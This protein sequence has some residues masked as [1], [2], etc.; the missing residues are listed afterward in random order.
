MYLDNAC[1]WTLRDN[2]YFTSCGEIVVDSGQG[3]EYC[4]CPYCG[5]RLSLWNN[6]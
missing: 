5:A 3:I 4:F 2:L 1:E 6:S